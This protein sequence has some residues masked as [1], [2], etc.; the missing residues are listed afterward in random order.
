M[1]SC[2]HALCSIF[3]GCWMRRK[4]TR[5]NRP[6]NST[7]RGATTRTLNSSTGRAL[8]LGR[9][10]VSQ[11]S[12]YHRRRRLKQRAHPTS[13][14][15]SARRRVKQRNPVLPGRSYKGGQ[16]QQDLHQFTTRSSVLMRALIA[17]GSRLAARVAAERG[18]TEYGSSNTRRTES[19]IC[20][21]RK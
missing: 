2:E 13:E 10:A 15:E 18:R 5:A 20:F 3:A 21:H 1:L 16:G 14:S 19:S 11:R 9:M 4:P 7:L 17:P 6:Q 12:S 8:L